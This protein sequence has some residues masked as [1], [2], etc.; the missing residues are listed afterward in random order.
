MTNAAGA[1]VMST[2]S[3]QYV[4]VPVNATKSG[5]PYNPTGDVVQFAFLLSIAGTPQSSDWVSGNWV[6]LPNYN[7]PYACQCLVGPGGTTTL[8]AGLYVIWV[9]I[10]DSPEIPVLIAGQLK[11]I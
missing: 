3:L 4:N 1:V 5:A 6:T 9:K 2:A 10:T 11:I 8:A 7:Y